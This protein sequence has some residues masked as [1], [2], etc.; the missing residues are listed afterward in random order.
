SKTQ[1]GGLQR[2]IYYVFAGLPPA[3]ETLFSFNFGYKGT[4]N[5]PNVQAEREK[6]ARKRFFVITSV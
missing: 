5:F 6:S 1:V 2:Y 3:T 4:T